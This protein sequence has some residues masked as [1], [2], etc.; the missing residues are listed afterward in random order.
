LKE[1]NTM[2]Q[3]KFRGSKKGKVFVPFKN[4]LVSISEIK[5][6]KN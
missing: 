1:M 6:I 4:D 2:I 5:W 3:T